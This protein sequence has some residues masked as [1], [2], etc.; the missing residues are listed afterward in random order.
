ME[1][2]ICKDCGRE[3]PLTDFRIT[4]GGGR[5]NMCNMC[6]TEKRAEM[7]YKRAQTGGGGKMPPFSDPDFDGRDPG[8]VWRQMCRAEKWLNSRE[9]YK[10]SLS[11]EYREVKIRKLKKE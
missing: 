4:K 6:I 5:A 2:K 11:G 10:V 3:L 9:G 7:R 8:E 1:T